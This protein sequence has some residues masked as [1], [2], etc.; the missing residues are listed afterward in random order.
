[1]KNIELTVNGNV[2]TVK[3]DLSKTHGA[4]G[5]GKSIIIASTEGNQVVAPGIMAGINVYKKA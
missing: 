4:S 5:S 3:I 1:M 2:L